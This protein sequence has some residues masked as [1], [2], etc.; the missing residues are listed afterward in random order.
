MP[1]AHGMPPSRKK[2]KKFWLHFQNQFSISNLRGT[3]IWDFQIAPLWHLNRLLLQLSSR[4]K[5]RCCMKSMINSI[6]KSYKLSSFWLRLLWLI[7]SS[8]RV[9]LFTSGNPILQNRTNTKFPAL[10]QRWRYGTGTA[11][12]FP[13]ILS[14]SWNCILEYF[15]IYENFILEKARMNLA[16]TWTFHWVPCRDSNTMLNRNKRIFSVLI[17]S[18]SIRLHC[19][20]KAWETFNFIDF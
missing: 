2:H 5:A 3:K 8:E 10:C 7:Y 9:V 14:G 13:L 19:N 18:H 11:W 17:T 1:F 12:N 20:S 15:C 4:G 6:R 16:Q